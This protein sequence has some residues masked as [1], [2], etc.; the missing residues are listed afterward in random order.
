MHT[1][2]HSFSETAL[3]RTQK[4]QQKV[5]YQI[6]GELEGIR[7]PPISTQLVKCC[8]KEVVNRK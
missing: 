1:S 4:L 7:L 5:D 2:G 6:A 8:V 3:L